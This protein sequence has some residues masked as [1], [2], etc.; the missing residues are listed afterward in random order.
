LGEEYL[1]LNLTKMEYNLQ[2]G[3]QPTIIIISEGRND[4][5]IKITTTVKVELTFWM[6]GK[7]G[8]NNMSYTQIKLKFTILI[9][10]I[11]SG[12]GMG[13]GMATTSRTICKY[14]DMGM[15]NECSTADECYCAKS[16]HRLL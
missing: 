6:A 2:L 5:W 9:N 3:L 1:I 7:S 11:K 12:A 14:C 10:E 15:H 8:N 16:G 4:Q 13:A